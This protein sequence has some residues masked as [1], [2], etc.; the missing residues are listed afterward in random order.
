MPDCHQAKPEASKGYNAFVQC[1]SRYKHY[2]FREENEVRIVTL[3]TF[4]DQELLKLKEADGAAL[5]PEKERKI[6][7]QNGKSI[8]KVCQIQNMK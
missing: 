4:F 6:R 5:K 8:L 7:N 1:I 2:G 3:P